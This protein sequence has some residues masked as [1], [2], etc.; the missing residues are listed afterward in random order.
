MRESPLRV[1]TAQATS[2]P[3]DVVSNVRRSA[4]MVAQSAADLVVFPELSLTGYEPGFIAASPDAWFSSDDGRLD[5]VRR[6][7]VDAGAT[8]V[9]GAPLRSASG[10]PRIGALVVDARGE[11]HV[12]YKQ[13]LHGSELALFEAGEAA[14]PLDIAGWR[15]SIAICFDA[16]KPRHAEAAAAQG[17]DVYV[18]SALYARGE[19]HRADLHLGARAM[20]QRMFTLL[21]NHAGTTGGHVACGG[22]GV[23]QPNGKVLVRA[24][25]SAE[26]MIAAE[27]DPAALRAFR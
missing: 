4:A 21:S 7:C 20:D 10:R 2:I 6:A 5:P 23:W 14:P 13:Y 9:L 19:E 24:R 15:V 12:S 22:S 11:V 8:A 18:V 3:G 26:E 17:A 25:S 27:L 16:A 1:A